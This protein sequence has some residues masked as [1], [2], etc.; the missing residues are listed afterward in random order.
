MQ[1]STPGAPEV[2]AATGAAVPLVADSRPAPSAGESKPAA[3]P[4]AP[5]QAPPAPSEPAVAPAARAIKLQVGGDGDSRVEVHLSQRGGDVVVAVRTPDSHLAG[6]LRADLPSLSA[7][8]EQS[9]YHAGSLPAAAERTHQADAQA[10]TVAPDAQSQPRQNGRQQ[11]EQ[12][13][14]KPKEPARP[15]TTPDSSGKDFAWLLSS[16]R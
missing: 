4:E 7:R 2:A 3:A 9:G 10:A 8:L 15:S 11:Q 5:A 12:Q 1:E 16:L 14:E 13:E 6:E